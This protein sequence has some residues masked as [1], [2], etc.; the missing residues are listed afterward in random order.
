MLKRISVQDLRVGMHLHELCGPWMQHPF[1]RTKFVVE[2]RKT[3]QLI[4][5]SNIQ[6]VVIDASKGLDVEVST[7]I[8]TAPP[9]NDG[10]STE[11]VSIEQEMA[12]A[13]QICAKAKQAV[14]SMFSEVRMGK[15]LD[16][17]DA[18]PL[19]EEISSSVMRNSGAL[20][21]LARLKTKDDYTYMH[22]VAVCA[23]MVS[24]SKQLGLDEEQT[25]LAG[26][27][28]L[29]HDVGKMAIPDEILDKPGKLTDEEFFVIQKH[30]M[31]GYDLL[32]NAN[33]ISQ[34]ALD[35]CRHHHE[36][37][38]GSGYP[39]KLAGD[40]ISLFAKMGA[41]CDVYDAITSNRP[42]KAGWGPAESLR[43]MAE[44]SKGHFDEKIFQSFVKS[45]GIFPIGSMV[46]LHS[47]RIAVVIDQSE[48][49]VAPIVKTFFSTKTN[50]R[51]T[52]GII[53]LATTH[54]P[55][56][57]IG[58]EDPDHWKFDDFDEL[59]SGMKPTMH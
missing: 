2:D 10:P 26:M 45:I 1:W 13:S 53:N 49:L 42:Y 22:S 25:R 11:P 19:V 31:A 39:D 3:I 9:R 16:A 57:I 38:D 44:W 37:I 58:H 51:I 43:K 35:V 34:A 33:G 12:Q 29:L 20:I 48:S 18:L 8:I 36:K 17:N 23:L 55:D 50:Q 54:N 46:R 52:P 27:A 7:P 59:W 28:G 47:G 56:K 40:Q 6:E 24:L 14:A 5:D 4:L 32:K 21:S 15:A 41:I 30:P